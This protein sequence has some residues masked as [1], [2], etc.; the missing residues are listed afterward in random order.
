MNRYQFLYWFPNRLISLFLLCLFAAT[1]VSACTD[2]LPTAVATSA[3]TTTATHSPEAQRP[4][5]LTYTPTLT[6]VIFEAAETL[7]VASPVTA[8]PPS[9]TSTP[10]L[11]S[12]PT[13]APVVETATSTPTA[14]PT[15]T[16]TQVPSPGPT[17]IPTPTVTPTPEPTA[18]HPPQPTP[19][20][21]ATPTPTIAPSPTPT[22]K[23]FTA[24][25][26]SES[27]PWFIDP[28]D[29]HHTTVADAIAEILDRH[30]DTAL[31]VSR[32][33][34]IVDGVT[35]VEAQASTAFKEIAAIDAETL[36]RLVGLIWI[37]DGLVPAE[38]EHLN[39]IAETLFDPISATEVLGYNWVQDGITEF[40]RPT[41]DALWII[42]S[43]DPDLARAVTTLDWV[44]D[45]MTRTETESLSKLRVMIAVDQSLGA[46][47][48][49]MPWFRN[50]IGFDEVEALEG[51]RLIAQRD[52]ELAKY[53]ADAPW[54][55]DTDQLTSHHYEPIRELSVISSGGSDLPKELVD[56]IAERIDQFERHLL[57]SLAFFR[58][59]QR[60]EFDLLRQ[61]QWFAD[62]LTREE[63]VF[64]ITAHGTVLN[65][66]E[67]FHEMLTSRYTQSKNI[68][69]PLSGNINIWAIQKTPFPENQDVATQIEVALRALEDLTLTPLSTNDVIVHFII[70]GP[71][72]NFRYLGGN[73]HAPWPRGG[74]DGTHIRMKREENAQ[75]SLRTLFHELAHYQFV[76]FPAWFI[77]G[78]ANFAAMYISQLH[79]EGSVETWKANTDTTV[80]PG[81]NNGA[82]NLHDLGNVGFGYQASPNVGCFY[83]IGE[84]FLT[85]VFHTIGQDATSSALRDILAIP[86]TQFRPIT[87]KDMFLAFHRYTTAEKKPKFIDL[88]NNLHGGPLLGE[89]TYPDDYHGDSSETATAIV[90]DIFIEG[91]LN[92]PFDIDYFAIPLIADQ[93]VLLTLDHEIQDEY[94]GED[95]YVTL[96]T[97]NGV[98]P[99]GLDSMQGTATS[100]HAEWVVPV[101]GDYYFALEST[102]GATGRYAMD[103][104]SIIEP[105]DAISP[106]I[107]EQRESRADTIEDLGD[108]AAG[109][110]DIAPGETFLA[111][112]DD[113]SDVDY[114]QLQAVEG[115]G[116]EVLVVNT[117]LEY[118]AIRA[119]KSDAKTLVDTTEWSDG[120]DVS[121]LKWLAVESS[122]HY[123]EVL[124]PEGNIGGYSITLNEVVTQDDDHGDDPESATV[125]QVSQ[126]VNGE[127][128]TPFDSDYFRFQ[129]EGGQFYNLLFNHYT[130]PAQPVTIYSPD[131]VSVI[132]EFMHSS[133]YDNTGSLIP[134]MAPESGQFFLRFSSPDGA[135]GDYRFIIVPGGAIEDDYVDTPETATELMVGEELAGSLDQVHDFDYFRFDAELG[136]RFFISLDYDDGSFDH[137]T[138]DL[139]VTVY[140]ADTFME[141]YRDRK[142]GKRQSGRF[143]QWPARETSYFVVV[144][145]TQGDIGPYT[146]SV[147]GGSS[148]NN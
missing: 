85:S 95:L 89:W 5:V 118:S 139:R 77:E 99:E 24:A 23:E 31:T 1:T 79:V 44:R 58:N 103:I 14:E 108:S 110:V 116:Y 68:D 10:A 147:S 40:E 105:I 66:P 9:S 86:R 57:A 27:I 126:M 114:F 32:L 91:A 128:T 70:P 54:V 132:H 20:P 17:R 62:G 81:C 45:G 74:H 26:I 51:F 35:N 29:E 82:A 142:E 48:V 88:F 52:P 69:L 50:G 106:S 90:T 33:R 80:G 34:W 18:T 134:W 38:I 4:P 43:A 109:A 87:S 36:T 148:S 64:I 129:A 101:S 124:S 113:N 28:P 122:V 135:T 61:Q 136:G 37:D 143:V 137:E 12:T 19:T 55:R 84:H 138:P 60:E 94:V 15:P 6:P 127:L 25:K 8:P 130:L 146:L 16:A 92:H 3:A 93:T 100:M 121:T 144:W 102:T 42:N 112:I 75:I 41:W 11:T 96:Q 67:D 59:E 98:N 7:Q 21:T 83:T 125:V 123:I 145:S 22:A 76:E 47:I 141:E 13:S 56:I 107:D 39:R 73:L 30:P 133:G 65:S 117:N 97:P 78:G 63:M 131:G 71:E 120:Y 104:M 49:A 140:V 115:R 2:T 111:R 72:S 46:R 53:I 119:F